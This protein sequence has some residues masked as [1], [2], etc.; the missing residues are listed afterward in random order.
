MEAEKV[1]PTTD[2]WDEFQLKL[3]AIKSK[4][5]KDKNQMARV[6]ME[7][8]NIVKEVHRHLESTKEKYK[9]L[10]T[11]YET[12]SKLYFASPPAEAAKK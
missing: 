5:C 7:L 11:H 12:V 4:Y 6:C 1:G 3:D 9:S 8:E 10:L 2:D